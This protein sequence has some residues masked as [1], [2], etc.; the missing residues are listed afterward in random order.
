MIGYISG[1]FVIG[2]LPALP[3]LYTL[4]SLPLF[5]FLLRYLPKKYRWHIG[6]CLCAS[7]WASL[8]GH[9]QLMHRLPTD[10]GRQEW[11]I[12]GTVEGLV[13]QQEGVR[14]FNV[15]LSS[16]H[17]YPLR[18]I[19][20]SEYNPSY[21]LSPGD[22]VSLQVRL[23]PVHG[24]ANPAGFD[25]EY[26][27]LTQGVDATGY[28]KAWLQP[29]R[30]AQTVISLARLRAWAIAGIET[31]FAFQ[32]DTAAT[33]TALI[34][35]DKS[36]LSDQH[37]QWLQRSGTTHLLIVSGLHIGVAVLVGWW[38][39]R[40]LALLLL[41]IIP[42]LSAR[43]LLIPVLSA[44]LLSGV[45]VLLAGFSLPTQRAWIM[46]AVMLTG[47]LRQKPISVWRRWWLAMAVVLTLQPLSFL[48]PGFWLSFG[49]VATLIFL[50]SVRL[51]GHG[52]KRFGYAQWGIAVALMPLLAI[53]FNG[54]SLSAPVVNLVA[55]PLVS[56]LV[57]LYIPA[58]LLTAMGVSGLN[59]LLSGLIEALWGWIAW[60]ADER[61]Y[62][63]LPSG[64]SLLG[65]GAALCG[66][67][68]FL[69]PWYTRYR[70]LG[71][72]MLLPLWL[73]VTRP[74]PEGSFA[75]WVF[76]VGQGNAVLIETG[77]H[78]LLYDTGMSYRSGGSVFERAVLPYLQQRG[79]QRLDKV[80]I[81]HA[82]N[83][84]AGGLTA[85]KQQLD[86]A[87]L[88]SGMPSEVSPDA[89]ICES[90]QQ[91][92]WEGVEFTYRHPP[93]VAS[94]EDNDRSCI[95]EISNG[96]CRLLLTGDASQTVERQV[97]VP[98]GRIHW[99][100]AGH[101][102]SNDSTA[103]T[104]LTRLNPETVLVS[105]GFLNRYGHPHPDVLARVSEH[106]EQ[107]WRTDLQGALYLRASLEEGCETSAYRNMK[108]RYWTAG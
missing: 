44:L 51:S 23:R 36:R 55:I 102:G 22:Y 34:L 71:V 4:A 42:W 50:L 45:Y 54:V 21:A 17:A 100:L 8:Y 5:I 13:E 92:F 70:V 94:A 95:L 84:H 19:R 80:V 96:V 38:V 59:H 78:W 7:L 53:F 3:S 56:L 52:L 90:Q 69:Q 12:T 87:V 48:M 58:L 105:A 101:H 106:T 86:I 18:R 81:S 61:F 97:V 40:V 76:D 27:L 107:I 60:W 91:W 49:A 89:R 75:A 57:S 85:L 41:P 37:W 32:P 1:F 93:L 15:E 65:V 20:L 62:L 46:A 64:V 2:L 47:L 28:I 25:Y 31:Q 104:F 11:Q 99:L 83:D 10:A 103:N 88:E 77:G 30:S 26:W 73:G 14:R 79:V 33:L 16:E 67:A 43:P 82:D 24:L 9:W 98:E 66:A 29:P 39:G 35:G 63:A 108:K 74:L 6:A 68:V 72:V